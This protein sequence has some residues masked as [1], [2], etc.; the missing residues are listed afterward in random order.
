MKGMDRIRRLFRLPLTEQRVDADVAAEVSFHLESRIEALVA[1][2]HSP[3]AAR[4]IA[5]R[6]FGDVRDARAELVRMDRERVRRHRRLDMVDALLHEVR[7]ATRSLVRAPLFSLT[8]ILT[9]G[10][11]IGV[12]AAMFGITDR[13]LFRAP[14]GIANASLVKRIYFTQT[15]KWAGVTHSRQSS[16][17]NYIALRDGLR[18]VDGVA[19]YFNMDAVQGRGHDAKKI[20]WSI[21]SSSLFPTLGAAPALGRFY[22]ADEDVAGKESRV[23]V[24]G[25]AFWKKQ[26]GGD[27]AALGQQLLIG[28]N[29]YTIIGVAQPGFNGIDYEPVDVFAPLSTAG[30]DHLGDDWDTRNVGWL[31]LV[32]RMRPQTDIRELNANAT[33]ILRRVDERF[34]TEKMTAT[35]EPVVLARAP[36]ENGNTTYETAHIALWL[37]GLSLLV[38]VIA[39]ANVINLML[40]RVNRRQREVGIRMAL[41]VGRGRLISAFTLESLILATAGG[42]AGLLLARWGSGLIRHLLLPDMDWSTGTIDRRVLLYTLVLLLICGVLSALAPTLQSLR[43]DLTN[44]LRSGTRGGSQRSL[45]RNALVALQTA[46]S[47]VLLVVAGLFVRSQMNL[48]D[49][50]KGFDADHVIA[51]NLD[52]DLL[53]IQGPAADAFNRT[54]AERLRHVPGVEDA[55]VAM[56]APFWSSMWGY[57]KAEG[58]DSIPQTRDGGPFYNGVTPTFFNTVGTRIVE[59]RGFTSDDRQGAP[60]V[61][62]LS[63]TMARLLWP[64]QNPIGKC[65]YFSPEKDCRRV[66]GIA[67]DAMRDAIEGDVM[68]FYLPLNQ[69]RPSSFRTVFIRA[70]DA[71]GV[72]PA[73]RRSL[74]DLRPDMPYVDMRILADL[75]SPQMRQWKLG[76]VLFSA[77]GLLALALASLGL[78]SV[79]AYNLAERAR[80]LSLRVALGARSTH[81]V[82]IVIGD[83]ARV[84]VIGLVIGL[85]AAVYASEKTASLLFHVAPWD[86]SVFVGVFAVLLGAAALAAFMP[87]LRAI[88]IAPVDALKEE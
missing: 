29:N 27:R 10:L 52:T 79:I 88:R 38:L 2:G 45:T 4:S 63:Q 71:T 75:M 20:R 14:P 7:F 41:G 42:G 72:Q 5:E 34:A 3:P 18:G 6:E 12:N 59:G 40:V 73:L 68:M 49:M 47:V 28:R 53:D 56:T 87:A 1:D 43:T 26:F 82:E 35:A 54:V 30:R 85:V 37:S 81:V 70:K 15:T 39:C 22:S 13:L 84:V 17:P 76:A 36:Q 46:T 80:E 33:S 60:K 66:V 55:A 24:L 8:V 62:V 19:A 25:Y 50:D 67:H 61:A 69:L 83:A 77:F 64:H 31:R 86:R 21:A 32:V 78:Y 11:G 9:L 58:V 57:I 51:V 48:R 23:I 16:Q 74:L 65:I 44:A